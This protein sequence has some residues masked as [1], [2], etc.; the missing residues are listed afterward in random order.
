MKVKVYLKTTECHIITYLLILFIIQLNQD[1][2][3]Y[4]GSYLHFQLLSYHISLSEKNLLI[5]LLIS[6]LPFYKIS[7]CSL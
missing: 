6:L 7:A 1:T 4:S 5:Y 2:D 3:I